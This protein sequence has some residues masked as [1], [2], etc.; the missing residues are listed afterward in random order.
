MT[1]KFYQHCE[2]LFLNWRDNNLNWEGVPSNLFD[3]DYSPEPYFIVKEG[4]NPLYMLLTNPG[5]PM[6]FQHR[7]NAVESYK[8][9]AAISREVYFSNQ[10]ANEGGVN[11]QRRLNK[12]IDFCQYLDYSGLINVETIPFHSATLDKNEAL[13]LPLKSNMIREYQEQLKSFLMDKP[14]L[15]VSACRSD[16]SIH[17]GSIDQNKWLTFQ[18]DLANINTSKLKMKKL[19]QKEDKTTSALF[20][21]GVKHIVLTMGSNNL[22][23][24]DSL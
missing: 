4:K 18:C 21:D 24:L 7:S 8:D 6:E 2:E 15:I 12:S 20:S 14:V 16:E 5:S 17:M 22:P 11:A 10:F 23:S 9:F 3:I 13:E 1:G 19:T